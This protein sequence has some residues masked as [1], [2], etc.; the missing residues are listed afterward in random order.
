MDVRY[1]N[2]FINSI[3]N[4]FRTMVG[5]KAEFSKPFLE[6]QPESYPDVSGVI[7]FSGDAGGAVA[8]CFARAVAL[9]TASAVVG[10]GL[11]VNDD[12]FRDAIGEL[13]NIVAGRAAA[14]FEGLS[15]RTGLPTVLIGDHHRNSPL[16]SYPRL[17]IPCRT[18]LGPFDVGVSMT[19]HAPPPPHKTPSRTASA[20]PV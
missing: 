7:V 20:V 2:P 5:C 11:S 17:M 9:R 15:I 8:L 13:A 14:D 6:T 12:Y 19:F 16:I 1:I 3:E 18:A 4:L 10:L